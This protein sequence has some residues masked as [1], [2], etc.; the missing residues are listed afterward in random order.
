M[1]VGFRICL[2]V[3]RKPATINKLLNEKQLL[4]NDMWNLL[5]YQLINRAVGSNCNNV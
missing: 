3:L 2:F 1:R 5:V 4:P